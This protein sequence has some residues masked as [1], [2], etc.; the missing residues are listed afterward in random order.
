M[1]KVR[2]NGKEIE[3]KE[4]ITLAEIVDKHVLA[5]RVNGALSDLSA[6]ISGDS[7]VEPI[8]FS[9]D[10]GKEIYWHSASHLMAMA[11]KQL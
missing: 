3:V 6:E 10:V 11:V 8:D 5:A 9:T 4:G 1:L 7:N 2:L